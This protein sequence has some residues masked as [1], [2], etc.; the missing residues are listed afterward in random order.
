MTGPYKSRTDGSA[1][2]RRVT[3]DL[4]SAD[5]AFLLTVLDHSRASLMPYQ[6]RAID[7]LRD[8]ITRRKNGPTVNA[9]RP[10]EAP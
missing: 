10:W 5:E 3:F 4:S 1:V 9:N 7:R 2:T 8:A 6:Q